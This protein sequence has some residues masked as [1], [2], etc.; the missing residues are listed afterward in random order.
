ML[1]VVCGNMMKVEDV[2]IIRV[3]Y[4][5]SNR[6]LGLT[7]LAFGSKTIFFFNI[8]SLINTFD[9]LIGTIF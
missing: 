9:K 6:V 2:Y 4:S 1:C 7:H 8:G 5:S 3:G